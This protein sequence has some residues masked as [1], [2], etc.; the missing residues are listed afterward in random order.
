MAEPF[1]SVPIRFEAAYRRAIAT[2]ISREIPPGL[3][4]HNIDE[5]L[6]QL[7][8]LSI[9]KDFID[10]CDKISLSMVRDVN[11][12]NVFSWRESARKSH[13]G[14]RISFKLHETRRGLVHESVEDEMSK[15]SYYIRSLPHKIAVRL[16]DEVEK[17]RIEGN[18]EQGCF[19][20]LRRRFNSLINQRI[21]LLAQTDP[22]RVNS[23][24]TEARSEDFGLNCF[25]WNTA[26]D[27]V[28]RISHQKMQGVVVFWRDLPS[29]EALM[30]KA[31]IFGHYPP[32]E[33]PN[34]RCGAIPILSV[35]DLFSSVFQRVKVYYD[36]Q[37]H[38]LT[39]TQFSKL[40][41]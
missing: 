41:T 7:E 15:S 11:L 9:D 23:S 32:G 21:N 25:I 18:T 4:Y 22:H 24:L 20:I 10:Q 17:A 39:R 36:D 30:H 6:N 28:V 37:I 19:H 34:C 33:C 12:H 16:K 40:L 8:S 35:D 5:W 14:S 13:L 31:P 27:E 26:R 2:V 3:S 29:P 38:Q 1:F